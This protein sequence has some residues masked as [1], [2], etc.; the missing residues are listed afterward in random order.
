MCKLEKSC[1][2]FLKI[3]I[4]PDDRKASTVRIDLVKK[5]DAPV[6]TQRSPSFHDREPFELETEMNH[7]LMRFREALDQGIFG[8]HSD[9]LQESFLERG[10]HL[11]R[12]GRTFDEMTVAGI[13]HQQLVLGTEMD[14]IME[15]LNRNTKVVPW[16]RDFS[17]VVTGYYKELEESVDRVLTR[18]RTQ[19]MDY[20]MEGVYGPNEEASE[21][22]EAMLR[23][24]Q[25]AGKISDEE[26]MPRSSSYWEI[27][28]SR[29]RHKKSM[30]Q[31]DA[32]TEEMEL[33]RVDRH[34]IS[35]R[36]H[37][38]VSMIQEGVPPGQTAHA[39]T[40]VTSDMMH[41]LGVNLGENGLKLMGTK[42]KRPLQRLPGGPLH[43]L[44]GMVSLVNVVIRDHEECVTLHRDLIGGRRAA[45]PMA[46]R[47]NEKGGPA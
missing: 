15:A 21:D 39:L 7:Y 30:L 46:W 31:P 10:P 28:E 4:M 22:I 40:R 41:H 42:G 29:E 5:A 18:I 38:V 2:V 47:A 44:E 35:G 8:S 27:S 23:K 12:A 33:A 14:P 9:M 13:G 17:T 26:L 16:G 43:Q 45:P 20:M 37:S 32:L 34:A 11:I 6:R 19:G 36:L 3:Q 1:T 25:E 24:L